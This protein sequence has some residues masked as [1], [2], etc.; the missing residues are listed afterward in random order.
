MLRELG[1]KESY[2]VR[3]FDI[4]QAIAYTGRGRTNFKK[5]AAQIGATRRFGRS[6]RYD[7]KVIDAALDAMSNEN[8]TA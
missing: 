3:L 5:W 7:R 4:E 2:E 6:V 8:V 1:Y